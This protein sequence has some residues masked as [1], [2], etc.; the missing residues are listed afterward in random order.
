M[1]VHYPLKHAK[2][3]CFHTNQI[4][5]MCWSLLKK[6]YPTS[7]MKVLQLGCQLPME[8]HQQKRKTL[9]DLYFQPDLETA[10]VRMLSRAKE[11]LTLRRRNEE[12]FRL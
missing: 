10:C 3:H 8:S 5:N 7:M 1:F 4:A 2:M 11:L 9:S 12:L 6:A